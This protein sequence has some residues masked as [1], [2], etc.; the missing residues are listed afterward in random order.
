VK[1]LFLEEDGIVG[2]DAMMDESEPQVGP[3]LSDEPA[4]LGAD[5]MVH[6]SEPQVGPTSSSELHS[7]VG[8]DVGIPLCPNNQLQFDT[9]GEKSLVEKDSSLDPGLSAAAEFPE[10]IGGDSIAGTAVKLSEHIG[11][12]LESG[13][14]KEVFLDVD[15][16]V[17]DMG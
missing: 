10:Y 9:Q 15:P 5:A 6:E 13:A 16:M 17:L 8:A 12:D 4:S 2:A 7:I 11:R 1:P 14:D 3:S